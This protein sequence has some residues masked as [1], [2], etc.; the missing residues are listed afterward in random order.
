MC[1]IKKVA[2]ASKTIE[3]GDPTAR[4]FPAQATSQPLLNKLE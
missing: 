1:S 2:F 3:K 4:I